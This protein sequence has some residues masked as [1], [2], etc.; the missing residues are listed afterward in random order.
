MDTKKFGK[1]VR[2]RRNNKHITENESV[3]VELA[4][5]RRKYR[6]NRKFVQVYK[7]NTCKTKIWYWFK[8]NNFKRNLEK[9][10]AHKRDKNY[11]KASSVSGS[12]LKI[13]G[14]INSDISFWGKT[15]E[16]K[17]YIVQG[18]SLNLLVGGLV[19]I[20]WLMKRIN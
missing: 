10:G 1:W 2:N 20:F 14:V 5:R 7:Q 11:R 16:V 12:K 4:S 17:A 13:E 8:H 18:L 3:K 9:I 15:G 19:T 6:S